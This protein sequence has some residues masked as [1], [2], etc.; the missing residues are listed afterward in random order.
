[1]RCQGA[2]IGTTSCAGE[3]DRDRERGKGPSTGWII[4]HGGKGAETGK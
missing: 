2:K 4:E 3:K 1:M